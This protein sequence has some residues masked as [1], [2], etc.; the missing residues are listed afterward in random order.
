LIFSLVILEGRPPL[1]P[2]ALEALS[3]ALVLSLISSLSNSASAEKILKV[4]KE[5]DEKV[6]Q[7]VLIKR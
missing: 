7:V 1:R 4:A 2:L 6:E 3:P 5:I